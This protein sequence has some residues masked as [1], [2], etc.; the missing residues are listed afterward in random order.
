MACPEESAASAGA[1]K[2]DVAIRVRSQRDYV[3]KQGLTYTEGVFAENTGSTNLCLHLLRIPPGGR[4]HA[5]LHANHET[6]IY[7]ISGHVTVLHGD[8]LRQQEEMDAGEFLYIPPNVPHL[9]INT[10]ATEAVAVLARSDP[11]V[12]LLPELDS[13]Q[14][15]PPEPAR[16]H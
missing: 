5:H 9:P 10:G 13:A 3:G 4:A 12:V 7:T 15:S 6:A 11:M 1:H 16:H 14:P 8:G 2:H